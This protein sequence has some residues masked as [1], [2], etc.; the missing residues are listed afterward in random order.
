MYFGTLRMKFI[1]FFGGTHI[2]PLHE[3][4]VV[5]FDLSGYI[6]APTLNTVHVLSTGKRSI[7]SRAFTFA[8][9]NVGNT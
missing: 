5:S 3:C 7:N 6:H 1:G 4:A 9:S 8:R 2:R